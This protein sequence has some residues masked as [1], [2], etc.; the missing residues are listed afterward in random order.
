MFCVYFQLVKEKKLYINPLTA[1]NLLK[2]INK[3]FLD[4][5]HFRE[6]RE[7]VDSLQDLSITEEPTIL[8]HPVNKSVF[9]IVQFLQKKIF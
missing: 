4:E 7:A 6:L 1:E 5:K 2:I 8:P 9:S 3:R